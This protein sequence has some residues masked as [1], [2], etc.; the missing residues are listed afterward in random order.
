LNKEKHQDFLLTQKSRLQPCKNHTH[1]PET[2]PRTQQEAQEIQ[3]MMVALPSQPYTSS[4][5]FNQAKN[6]SKTNQDL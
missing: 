5:S 6:S 2:T 1:K 4:S 3:N